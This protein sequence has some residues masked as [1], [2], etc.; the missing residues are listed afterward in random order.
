MMCDIV[1]EQEPP[2]VRVQARH[3]RVGAE[4]VIDGH[5]YRVHRIQCA[6][7]IRRGQD[8][9]KCCLYLYNVKT[10]QEH[11]HVVAAV[12]FIDIVGSKQNQTA[13]EAPVGG[14]D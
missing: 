6:G 9:R 4:C 14:A 7:M 11:Q 13:N 10:A 12:Q 3:L 1:Q 5:R 8:S 2:R